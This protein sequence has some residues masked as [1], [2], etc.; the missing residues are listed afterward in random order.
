[1]GMYE[2]KKHSKIEQAPTG[3]GYIYPMH[4]GDY[5]WLLDH[6]S[7]LHCGPSYAIIGRE[8]MQPSQEV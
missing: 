6:F 1:M 4:K 5:F 2:E 8:Q 3:G 7:N